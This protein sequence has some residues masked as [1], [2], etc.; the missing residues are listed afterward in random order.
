LVLALGQGLLNEVSARLAE[1][2]SL[3]QEATGQLVQSW[4]V[5]AS[6]LIANLADALAAAPVHLGPTAEGQADI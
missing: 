3:L 4:V 1:H 5:A 6:N 2:P